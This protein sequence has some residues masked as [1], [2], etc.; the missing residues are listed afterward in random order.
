MI[1]TQKLL[2]VKSS[3]FV[4]LFTVNI[5]FGAILSVV[6]LYWKKFL[7]PVNPESVEGSWRRRMSHRFDFYL[8]LLV[9]FL[10]AAVFGLV[11]N[12]YINTL[13]ESVV[14]V[15]V[16]LVLGGVV[17]LFADNWFNRP[18]ENQVISYP[19][20]LKIGFFQ[21]ISMIPGV[22][23]AAATIIGGLSQGLSRK[24]AAEFSFFLAVPTM[25]AASLLE[26]YKTYRIITADN[27]R[28]LL[29]GNAV[30]FV[31]AMLAIKGFISFLTIHGFRIFGYYRIIVGL[32]ILILLALGIDLKMVG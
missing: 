27:I 22:S 5:Q 30:A 19:K 17:L 14:V 29:L 1:I 8:K 11:F 21:V 6:V 25:L 24:N 28:L 16:S 10:P 4:N 20:A 18:V 26:M 12:D 32:V 9:A 7:E 15:A 2:G 23:R 3:D 31:V 13:L